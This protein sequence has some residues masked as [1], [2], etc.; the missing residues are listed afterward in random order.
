M[1]QTANTYNRIEQTLELD[2]V[3]IA[4]VGKVYDEP[5]DKWRALIAYAELLEKVGLTASASYIRG[6]VRE[7]HKDECLAS[8]VCPYCG[9]DAVKQGSTENHPAPFGSG[10]VSEKRST[11]VCSGTCGE[12]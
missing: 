1:E 7:T 9:E 2:E 8:G 5:A 4:G 6:Y 12:V 3:I 11:Y 10:T